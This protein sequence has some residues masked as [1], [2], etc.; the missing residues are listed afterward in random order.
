MGINTAPRPLSRRNT[1]TSSATIVPPPPSHSTVVVRS[2]MTVKPE[3]RA[4]IL[5][6]VESN[7][8]AFPAGLLTCDYLSDS[9]TTAMTD[10]QWAALMRG[11]ES[12]GRNWGYYCLLDTFRD[13]FER[14]NNPQ[15]AF[16]EV[17]TGTVDSDFYREKLLVPSEGGF[18]NGGPHQLERPN[19]FIVPQGRC[20]E[21]LLFFTMYTMLAERGEA[22]TS[23]PPV[24]ISN[25]FFDTTGAN[26]GAAGFELQEFLKPGLNDAFPAELIGK[27]NFFKGDL[28]IPATEAYMDQN[29]G[30]TKMILTTI[31]NNQAAGQPV[32]MTNIRATAAL[33]K[34]KNVPFFF[35]A[36]RFAENA[37]F[38]HEYE[39]GYSDKTIPEIVQEMF[40]YVD[41]FTISLK[42]D[43]LTNIG[44][45]LCFRDRGLFTQQYEGVGHRLKEKQ[46]L[47]YGNDSYGGMSGRD[48]MTAAT[49]L[50]EAIKEPYLRSRITQVQSFAQKLHANG[51]SPV[52]P[53]G[54]H[55]VYLDM[56]KFFAD[57]NRKPDDFASVGFTLELIKEFGIR[58]CEIGPFMFEWDR[59]TPERRKK[60]PDFVRFAVPRLVLSQ[61][62]VD[63]TV[64]AVRSLYERR[65]GIPN[66]V[67]TR[68]KDMRLR[69]FSAGLKSV[70]VKEESSADKSDGVRR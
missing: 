62:H 63:Y 30:R 58:A 59:A 1:G 6:E 25:G 56:G 53:P 17:I 48:V 47:A 51:L 33:A 41:G 5:E 11:D 14:G 26:A 12:Y 23:S 49:G 15:R 46:I 4:Q 67:I 45:A 68:G 57:C 42:K 32:S 44:G 61:E 69:H 9:G 31:T 60:I 39:A 16:Q 50:H 38:I 27:K 29:P 35:D 40:S 2:L 55:A 20:A 66:V 22:P 24:I 3:E 10:V 37:F 54:G 13:V 8:F 65:D 34:R 64:A 19:F 28:D 21:T 70:P 52:L 18:V 7:V 36:C 43:G